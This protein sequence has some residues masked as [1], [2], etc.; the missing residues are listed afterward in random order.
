M[1]KTTKLLKEVKE[2]NKWNKGSPF[3]WRRRLNMVKMSVLPHLIY[4]INAVTMKIPA[5][6]FVDINKLVLR[7]M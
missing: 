2:L 6:H 1:K 3:S 7:F 5:N 4:R